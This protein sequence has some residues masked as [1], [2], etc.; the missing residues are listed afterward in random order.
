[1]AAS[2]APLATVIHLASGHVLAAFFT[3]GREPTLE[4]LTAANHLRVRIPGTPGFVNVPISALTAARIPATADVLDR[5][6]HYRLGT[7]DPAL[8]L[9]KPPI[10]QGKVADDA[11]GKPAIV[12]WQTSDEPIVA[13]GPVGADGVPPGTRPPGATH[14]LLVYEGGPLHLNALGSGQ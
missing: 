5:P 8:I 14:A 10:F 13:S 11:V 1:M 4:D 12:V 7:G 9:A 6:Q 2:P 3:G